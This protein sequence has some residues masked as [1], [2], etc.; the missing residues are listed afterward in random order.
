VKDG[1]H[2][3]ETQL[4]RLSELERRVLEKLLR[5]ET[6]ARDTVATFEGQLSLGDRVAD[7]VATFGGSWTFILLFVVTM[8][9]WIAFNSVTAQPFDPFPF[10]L[11]NLGLSC[12]AALQAPVILMSQNRMAS[13]DRLDARHDYEVNLKAETEIGGLHEKMD[14]LRE[15]ELVELAAL[16]ERQTQTLARIEEHL[17]ARGNG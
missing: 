1:L 6:V 15:R 11:L 14:Q 9:V 4:H 17:A 10:I 3:I 5:R 16:I 8:L 7:R 2:E 13:M 12:L